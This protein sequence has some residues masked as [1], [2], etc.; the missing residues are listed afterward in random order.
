MNTPTH[1]N[2]SVIDMLG[3]N[4]RASTDIVFDVAT[5]TS[6]DIVFGV[7]TITITDIEFGVTTITTD[8]GSCSVL[9][10]RC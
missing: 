10:A 4:L 1:S 9:E 6:T 8:V 3:V 7:V 5:I 2:A